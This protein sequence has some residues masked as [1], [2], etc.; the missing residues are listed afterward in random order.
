MHFFLGENGVELSQL[1]FLLI[2][3]PDFLLLMSSPSWD[4][5]T[6]NCITFFFPGPMGS[7]GP[8][9]PPGATGQPGDE[10]FQGKPGP[11]GPT[12]IYE[13]VAHFH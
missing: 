2:K 1:F 11:R 9:G 8:Q 10:G 6:S 4:A 12:G 3:Q 5:T 13:L 7:H